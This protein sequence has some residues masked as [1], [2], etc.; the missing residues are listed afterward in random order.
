MG[1][2]NCVYSCDLRPPQPIQKIFHF[3][4]K[5]RLCPFVVSPVPPT[6]QPWSAF[7]HYWLVLFVVE[8][9][10]NGFLQYVWFHVWLFSLSIMFL[11]FIHVIVYVRGSFLFI[12][13]QHSIVRICHSWFIHSQSD[14]LAGRHGEDPSPGGRER[15]LHWTSLGKHPWPQ[16]TL[17]LCSSPG[18]FFPVHYLSWLHLKRKLRNTPLFE[19]FLSPCM[20]YGSSGGRRVAWHFQQL[21]ICSFLGNV[22]LSETENAPDLFAFSQFQVPQFFPRHTSSV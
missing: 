7:Y 9:H 15:F 2:D 19:H 6:M 1:L 13:E 5:F 14:V 10:I 17:T 12:S 22:V 4:Q 20:A 3:P 21:K 8:L 16:F 11:R 18:R